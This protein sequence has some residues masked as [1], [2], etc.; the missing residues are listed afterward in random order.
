VLPVE[1][2][3]DFA[4]PEKTSLSRYGLKARR[5]F[6]TSPLTPRGEICPLGGMFIHPQE[7]TLSTV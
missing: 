3:D 7:C 5:P 4:H 1:L 2:D 6:L